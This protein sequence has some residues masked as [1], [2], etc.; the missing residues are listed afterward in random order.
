MLKK[1][2][3]FESDAPGGRPFA[4]MRSDIDPLHLAAEAD[5]AGLE[6]FMEATIAAAMI[7]AHADGAADLVERRRII[8]LFRA[9]RLLQGFSADDISREIA[10]HSEA[11]AFDT[12]TALRRAQDQIANAGLTPRQFDIM[13][14][15]C[16]AVLEADG[17]RHPAEET[18]LAHIADLGRRSLN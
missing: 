5:V 12:H 18:A 6:P 16:V 14:G 10:S 7:I 15:I 8:S 4:A 1:S 17:V 2:R 3:P 9:N 13:I 11:F